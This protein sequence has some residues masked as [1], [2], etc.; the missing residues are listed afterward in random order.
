MSA[1]TLAVNPATAYR[2]LSDFGDL[3]PGDCVIQNGANSGVGQ[4]VIQIAARMSVTTINVIR[5]G[6][7]NHDE[8][9]AYL[10]SLG[11]THVVTDEHLKSK[12]MADLVRSVGAPRLALNCVGG[13]A[14]VDLVRHVADRGVAVTYGG[15]SRQPLSVPAGPLIFGDVM[16]RGFWNSRWNAEHRGL[17][18]W[19]PLWVFLSVIC[20]VPTGPEKFMKSHE[21]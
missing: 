3:A 18:W 11:A 2:L 15:M 9:V 17:Y 1:A 19:L 5:S 13:R 14:F 20:S 10:K 12:E 21:I 8:V 4:A 16:L 6:R 7:P